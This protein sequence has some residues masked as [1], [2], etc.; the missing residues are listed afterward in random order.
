MTKQFV[1]SLARREKYRASGVAHKAQV[2]RMLGKCER[3]PAL[4]R[5]IDPIRTTL[6]EAVQR[7]E[8]DD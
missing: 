8:I 6:V 3:W 1:G 7:G 4:N 2:R 5:E